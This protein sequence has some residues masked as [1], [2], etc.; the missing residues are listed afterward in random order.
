L[1]KYFQQYAQYR[2]DESET[3]TQSVH[4]PTRFV[5]CTYDKYNEISF[6]SKSGNIS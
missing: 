5:G 6:T 4:I 1:S 3:L 2:T